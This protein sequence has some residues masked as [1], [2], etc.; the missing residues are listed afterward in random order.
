MTTEEKKEQIIKKLFDIDTSLWKKEDWTF[1]AE[2]WGWKIVV[3]TPTP[4][5]V[6]VDGV[7]IYSP[8]ASELAGLIEAEYK[9]R[10]NATEESRIDEIYRRL[11]S[12]AQMD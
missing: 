6:D 3:Y 1:T 9:R 5:S 12:S 7:P 8:R 2:Y 4:A 11:T 10:K